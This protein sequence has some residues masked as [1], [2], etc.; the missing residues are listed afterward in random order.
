MPSAP[1]QGSS[2]IEDFVIELIEDAL[3]AAI[4]SSIDTLPLLN[5]ASEVKEEGPDLETSL[6][7]A[8]RVG[9]GLMRG[10]DSGGPLECDGSLTR[11]AA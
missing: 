5:T 6:S 8:A 2:E 9:V 7:T 11:K 3:V 1:R 4:E 10:E